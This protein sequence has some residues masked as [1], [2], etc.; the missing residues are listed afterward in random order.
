MISFQFN[1]QKWG[2]FCQLLPAKEGWNKS[3][4]PG[5]GGTL[6]QAVQSEMFVRIIVRLSPTVACFEVKNLGD[7]ICPSSRVTL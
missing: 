6:P 3:V 2:A 1:R 7:F 5:M 4:A